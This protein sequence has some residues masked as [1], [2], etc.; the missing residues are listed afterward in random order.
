MNIFFLYWTLSYNFQLHQITSLSYPQSLFFQLSKVSRFFKVFHPCFLLRILYPCIMLG[1]SLGSQSCSAI[2]QY[3]EAIFISILLT[4]SLFTVNIKSSL[5]YSIMYFKKV[6]LVSFWYIETEKNSRS[7]C[8]LVCRIWQRIISHQ[9][10]TT[11]ACVRVCSVMSSS[12][13]PHRL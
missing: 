7:M 4:F 12:L 2:A 3:L 8:L 9:Y 1:W 11:N 10:I 5:F 13:Q 6:F